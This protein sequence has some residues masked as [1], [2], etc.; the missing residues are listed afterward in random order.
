MAVAD[1]GRHAGHARKLLRCALRVAAGYDDF[2]GRVSTMRAADERTS[3]AI[4]LGR[5]AAS[6]DYDHVGCER[7][8]IGKNA[9]AAGDGLAIGARRTATEVLNVKAGHHIQFSEFPAVERLA[10][11]KAGDIGLE[12]I[13][14]EEF[15]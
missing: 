7:F 12:R 15:E 4:G 2:G 3:G 11:C 10:E 8:A 5:Y 1:D 14:V 6:V 9:K 13:S